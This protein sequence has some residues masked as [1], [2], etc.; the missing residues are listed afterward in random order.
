MSKRKTAGSEKYPAKRVKRDTSPVANITGTTQSVRKLGANAIPRLTTTALRAFVADILGQLPKDEEE[1]N[2][3]TLR[4]V[5]MLPEHLLKELWSQMINA[6]P[7]FVGHNLIIEIFLRGST[8][9]FPGTLPGIKKQTVRALSKIGSTLKWLEIMGHD[10]PDQDFAMTLSSLPLLEHLNLRHSRQVGSRTCKAIYTTHELLTYLNL[11]ETNA[12][13]PDIKPILRKLGK[14]QVL[15]ISSMEGLT[16]S[17]ITRT[18]EELFGSQPQF[19]DQGVVPLSNL[20]S[21]KLRHTSITGTTIA[22]ILPH[23]PMLQTLDASFVPIVSI[24]TVKIDTVPK[25]TK[26][27]LASTPVDAKQLLPILELLPTL[28][29]LNLGALGASAKTATGFTIAGK[30]STS[31]MG[32]R[33]LDDTALLSL[34]DILQ[35]FHNLESVSLAGNSSLCTT[36]SRAVSYFIRQVGRKLKMLNLNGIPLLKSEDLEGLRAENADDVCSLEQLLLMGTSIDDGVAAHISAC[37]NLNFLDLEATKVSEEGVLD[38]ID[39]CSLLETINLSSCRGIGVQNRRKIFE[40]WKRERN[41]EDINGAESATPRERLAY[42]K[43]SLE[44]RSEIVLAG[45]WIEEKI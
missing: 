23:L 10:I 18:V 29:I 25:L 21:L 44:S 1:K 26:L 9:R 22:L 37:P 30:Q 20:R 2:K 28:K 33:T 35:S 14:L 17:E 27:S 19:S 31:A 5:R 36:K 12:T 42:G 38:I 16:D 34:T 13:L 3:R 41:P 15:K 6:W 4:I 32:S 7:K 8:I 39:A 40:L 43:G 24:P 11:G 45:R